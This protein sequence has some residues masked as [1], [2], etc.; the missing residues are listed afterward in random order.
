M[1]T[2]TDLKRQGYRQQRLASLGAAV[3]LVSGCGSH[4]ALFECA[5]HIAQVL[6][7][8]NLQDLGDGLL[9]CIPFY[10]IPNEELNEALLKLSKRFSIALVE[11]SDRGSYIALWRIDRSPEF[12]EISNPLLAQSTNLNDY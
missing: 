9:E 7:T 8:R 5:S 4:S 12:V 2:L 3:T 6:G 1:P 10:R 11:Y